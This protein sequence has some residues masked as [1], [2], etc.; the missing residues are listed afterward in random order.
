LL[1]RL[2]TVLRC[3]KP[4]RQNV[5][6]ANIVLRGAN[7]AAPVLVDFGLSFNDEAEDDLTRVGD[8]IGNRFLRLPEHTLG[9]RTTASD[10]TQL[11]GIFVYLLTG[12][13]PRMLDD[14]A[15]R[16]PHRREPVHAVLAALFKNRQLLRLQS[17]FDKAFNNNALG[18]YQFAPDLIADLKSALADGPNSDDDLASLLTRVDE[19]ALHAE[20]VAIARRREGLDHAMQLV[21]GVIRSFAKERHL[22]MRSTG[23]A[24]EL[25]Q[26]GGSIKRKIAVF[27]DGQDGTSV[28]YR[29]EARDP[30]E[31][32]LLADGVEVWRGKKDPSGSTLRDAV[33]L[34]AAERF[35]SDSTDG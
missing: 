17:V 16:K 34:V 32:V 8:E 13:E 31:F 6:R 15:G 5:F 4:P 19:I 24:P 2:S 33:I 9:I 20:R 23:Y 7:L 28:T 11:A 30:D 10:V 21:H 3:S 35:V 27:M 22:N 14:D 29:V 18:R 12:I 25:T 1:K 26:D